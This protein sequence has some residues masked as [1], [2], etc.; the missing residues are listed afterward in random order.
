MFIEHHLVPSLDVPLAIG[1]MCLLFEERMYTNLIV[2]HPGAHL[3]NSAGWYSIFGL[4]C[5]FYWLP[6]L[7]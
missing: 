7:K 5:R 3:F 4:S 1:K 6:F 2:D